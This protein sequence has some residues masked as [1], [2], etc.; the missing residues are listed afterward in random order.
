M[1]SIDYTIAIGGLMVFLY[2]NLMLKA[3]SLAAG[4]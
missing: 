4:R 1:S 3:F 2:I